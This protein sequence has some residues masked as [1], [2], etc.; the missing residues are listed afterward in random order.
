MKLQAKR[1]LA[2]FLL[3]VF[4]S[5]QILAVVPFLHSLVHPDCHKSGHQCGV[6]L[7]AHGKID[8]AD[9]AVSIVSTPVVEIAQERIVERPLISLEL[10]L[11]PGR[12][13]PFPA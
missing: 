10:P 9:G 12:G 7:F 8:A 2:A 13:P 6:T 11:P 4:A 3:A 5:L 1:R